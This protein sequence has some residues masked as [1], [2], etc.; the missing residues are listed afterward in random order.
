[1]SKHDFA[2]FPSFTA[3]PFLAHGVWAPGSHLQWYLRL[4]AEVRGFEVCGCLDN[5]DPQFFRLLKAVDLLF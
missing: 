2:I 1:M 5:I 3:V 4:M